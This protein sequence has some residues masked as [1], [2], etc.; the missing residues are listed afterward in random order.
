MI[1]LLM[2][3]HDTTTI[4]MSS[5]AYHLARFPEWQEKAREEALAAGDDYDAIIGMELHER[6]MKESLRLCSPVPNMPR[7]ATKETAV[8]G[9]RIP[10]GAFVTVSPFYNHHDPEYWPDPTH[11][12]PGPVRRAAPRG[13][14]PPDGV[15]GVRR[16]RAQVH[17]DVLRRRPGARDLPRAAAHLPLVGRP[18][19][20]AG[21]WTWS[22][23]RSRAT[24]SR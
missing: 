3:A 11:L 24:G 2:A 14:R 8:N 17:R 5:M 15:P 6:I 1:F 18:P 12:R 20:T 22:R 4:T 23:C 10:E 13:P 16:R 19:T 9:Y 7:V 21:R